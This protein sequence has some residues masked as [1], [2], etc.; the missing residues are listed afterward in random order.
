MFLNILKKIL[1]SPNSSIN[2]CLFVS[3]FLQLIASGQVSAFIFF[4]W[5]CTQ[6]SITSILFFQTCHFLGHIVFCKAVS[7]IFDYGL[8]MAFET[9]NVNL[10]FCLSLC[11]ESIF[12]SSIVPIYSTLICIIELSWSTWFEILL[13][14]TKQEGVHPRQASC[15]CAAVYKIA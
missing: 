3:F 7:F 8:T 5:F 6:M 9:Q 12:E 14:E 10:Y 15:E 2:R 11:Q 1:T 4:H 13:D